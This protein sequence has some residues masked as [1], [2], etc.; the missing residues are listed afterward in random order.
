LKSDEFRNELEKLGGYSIDN[1]GE[2][3]TDK[4]VIS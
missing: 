3:I 2:L 1:I 4:E